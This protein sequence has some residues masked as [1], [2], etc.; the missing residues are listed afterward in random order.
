MLD[1]R[2]LEIRIVVAVIVGLVMGAVVAYLGFRRKFKQEKA[3]LRQ[4]F[5]QVIEENER[6]FQDRL[7]SS[8][9]VL[10]TEHEQALQAIQKAP[11][12]STD[13]SGIVH[14]QPL[15]TISVDGHPEESAHGAP[16]AGNPVVE[17][18]SKIPSSLVQVEAWGNSGLV[19]AIPG[20]S[21]YALTADQKTR[22]Q[23]AVALGK[24]ANRAGLRSEVQT[25]LGILAKLSRDPEI[26]VRCAA[27]EAIAQIPS[28][29]SI[30]LLNQALRDSAGEVVQNASKGLTRL[31]NVK[32]T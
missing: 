20:L 16:V 8:M 4:Q 13:S 30:R 18:A 32:L 17:G 24:I 27:V 3:K 10:Q 29:R 6:I 21:R 7:Q 9:T 23:V 25:S 2:S 19:S 28:S 26:A 1:T 5:Q 31:K 12:A 14:D 22:Q 15:M 11:P